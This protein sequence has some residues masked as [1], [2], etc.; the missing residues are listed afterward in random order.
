MQLRIVYGIEVRVN[1]N[2]TFIGLVPIENNIDVEFLYYLM[3]FL[4]RELNRLS[5]GTTISYLSREEFE[6]F[7]IKIPESEEQKAIAQILTTADSEININEKYLFE[8]QTQKKGLMQ[9]L[10][11]G[12]VRVKTD[13]KEIAWWQ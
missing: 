7:K 3:I 8:L 11:T 12:E 1:T 6:E 10:L 4:E 9:K 2:Q 13:I 5:S